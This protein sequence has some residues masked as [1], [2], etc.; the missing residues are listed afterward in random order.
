MNQTKTVRGVD[1]V[2]GE[3]LLAVPDAEEFLVDIDC[4]QASIEKDLIDLRGARQAEQL[5]ISSL[6]VNLNLLADRMKRAHADWG[7]RKKE[8]QAG[9]EDVAALFPRLGFRVIKDLPDVPA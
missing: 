1:R 5:A 9:A 4:L 7:D 6:R 2:V 3:L 8:I